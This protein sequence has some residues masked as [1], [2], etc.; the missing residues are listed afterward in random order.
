MLSD[1][2]RLSILG[3]F[4]QRESERGPPSLLQEVS[5]V[6]F[7]LFV[8]LFSVTAVKR[9]AGGGMNAASPP[10]R[11]REGDSVCF[12][13]KLCHANGALALIISLLCLCFATFLYSG[14]RI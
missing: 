12:V 10:G 3:Q 11:E 6:V 13:L 9:E 5:I 2:G 4:G 1:R 7:F 14:C 8:Y